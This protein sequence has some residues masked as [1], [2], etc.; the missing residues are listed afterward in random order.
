MVSCPGSSPYLPEGTLGLQEGDDDEKWDAAHGGASQE[1]A[2][3]VSPGRVHID[4]VVSER[5]VLAQG[6]E[7]SGLERQRED[8]DAGGARETL[9]SGR[10][11]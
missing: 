7:E 11:S 10:S 5:C 3:E 8:T 1:P 2:D 9:S 4:V 6:E